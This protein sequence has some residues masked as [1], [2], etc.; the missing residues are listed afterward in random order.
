MEEIDYDMSPYINPDCYIENVILEQVVRLYIIF[1]V[2]ENTRFK[3]NTR[4]EIA[5]IQW[6]DIYKLPT[7]KKDKKALKGT[8]FTTNNF[9]VSIPHVK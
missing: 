8:N 7:H 9:F 5:D 2:P 1:G 4:K 3:T 6:F